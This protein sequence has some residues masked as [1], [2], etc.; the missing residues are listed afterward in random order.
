[1]LTP[2]MLP[3]VSPSWWILLPFLRRA[4]FGLAAFGLAACSADTNDL[5]DAG[6]PDADMGPT[7]VVEPD[8][9]TDED[10]LAVWGRAADDV[11]AVGWAGTIIHYDG[12]AWT[13]EA[14][15]ATVPLTA[16]HGLPLPEM[17]DPAD[18]PPPVFVTGW[19]GHLLS[20][21]AD[22]SWSRVGP[23]TVAEDLFGIHVAD[24]DS[25]LAVGDSGRLMV[26][27]GMDWIARPLA[28]PGEFSGEI[29][30]PKGTLKG[31]WSRNGNRYY[32]SG[33]GGAAYRSNNGLASYEAIDTRISAPLRGLWGTGNNNVYAVGLEGLILRFSGEWRVIRNNGADELPKAFLFGIDGAAGDDITIVGWRGVVA[34]FLDGQW[35]EEDS[36]VETDLRDVWV[37]QETGVAYAVGASGTV[38][39]R[40]P[41][42]PPEEMPMMP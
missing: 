20:R 33:S 10:L 22:G 24:D 30:E 15:T 3:R 14:S 21:A 17:P 29:I 38:I 8:I 41:P 40:D 11:W 6:L 12:L 25:A 1:M 7:W 4:A 28:V 5:P 18:P 23:S 27:D 42:P 35:T 16:I 13:L 39:R 37:D 36:M 19:Q 26:W 9:P 34:R 31:V 32:I 2:K